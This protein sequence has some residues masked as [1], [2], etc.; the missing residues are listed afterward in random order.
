[1][2]EYT[3]EKYAELFDTMGVLSHAGVAA[4]RTKTIKAGRM[5]EAECFP[6]FA[7]RADVM[8]LQEKKRRVPPEVMKRANERN[9]M[10]KMQRLAHANFGEGDFW[11]TVTYA[12]GESV[13][14]EQA[15]K[16]MRNYIARIQRARKRAGLEQTKYIYVVEWGETTG[17]IHCHII[18]ERMDW[19]TVHGLWKHGRTEVQK[20]QEDEKQGL[21]EC[22]K[23][24]L[25]KTTPNPQGIRRKEKAWVASKGMKQPEETRSDR[26]VSRR[27]VEKIAK[28][29]VGDMSEARAIFEKAYPGYKL[30]GVNVKLC[31]WATG[32]YIYATMYKEERNA[33]RRGQRTGGIV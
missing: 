17:R 33:P 8:R 6:I 24:M 10:K 3:A 13:T 23:Y 27:K 4:Y 18:M 29:M 12:Q 7:G 9:S 28:A 20:L 16:D 11:V 19:D 22:V 31:E 21:A 5:L 25:K 32:A 1:M 26:K 15:M 2:Q 30:A 14:R